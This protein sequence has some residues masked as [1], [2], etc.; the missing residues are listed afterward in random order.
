MCE[1]NQLSNYWEIGSHYMECWLLYQQ[2]LSVWAAI[3]CQLSF[4]PLPLRTASEL[5]NRV[6]EWMFCQINF[7][8]TSLKCIDNR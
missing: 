4:S 8:E 5:T 2:I 3:V 6:N 1:Y 7:P